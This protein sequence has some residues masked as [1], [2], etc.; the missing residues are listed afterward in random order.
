[1]YANSVG[2]WQRHA[3]SPPPA[4]PSH[5]KQYCQQNAR[6]NTLAHTHPTHQPLTLILAHAIGEQTKVELA[7]VLFGFAQ[8]FSNGN[9][10]FDM[11]LQ[12]ISKNVTGLGGSRPVRYLVMEVKKVFIYIYK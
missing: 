9:G 12:K 4:Q 5:C 6:K 7:R 10:I 2:I 1:M 8:R 3:L 11:S